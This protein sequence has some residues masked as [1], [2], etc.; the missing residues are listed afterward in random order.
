MFEL[1][2]LLDAIDADHVDDL[3]ANIA[4]TVGAAPMCDIARKYE[5]RDWTKAARRWWQRAARLSANRL[6][7]PDTT[8]R[9][10]TAR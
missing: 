9:C 4:A 8:W 7:S 3:V 6:I 1:V 5:Q 2:R 10:C